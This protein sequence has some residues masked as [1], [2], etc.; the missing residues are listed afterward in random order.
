MC[1]I[2]IMMQQHERFGLDRILT[3][4]LPIAHT[5]IIECMPTSQ[6]L[7][8]RRRSAIAVDHLQVHCFSSKMVVSAVCILVAVTAVHLLS[9]C[10]T[11]SLCARVL[12]KVGALVSP[13]PRL[14]RNRNRCHLAIAI[15]LCTKWWVGLDDERDVILTS[16]AGA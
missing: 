4:L 10:E 13:P 14:T 11:G 5:R 3:T 15:A 1:S 2:A 12:K 16:G 7:L 8:D 9:A 6:I